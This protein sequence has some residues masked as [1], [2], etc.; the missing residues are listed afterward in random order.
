MAAIHSRSQREKA[1]GARE[2]PAPKKRGEDVAAPVASSLVEGPTIAD[3]W[4]ARDV[5]RAHVGET[6]ILHSRT[7][8][9]MTGADVYLKAENLQRSGSFKLRGAT[10]KIAQLSEA[11]R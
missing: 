4:H 7:F 11:E 3:I 2:H 6:P 5:L 9:A 1:N 8:S 10:Y